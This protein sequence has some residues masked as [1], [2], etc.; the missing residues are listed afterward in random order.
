MFVKKTTKEQIESALSRLRS[1]F[2]EIK[3]IED[4]PVKKYM[5]RWLATFAPD[6]PLYDAKSFCLPRKLYKNY[7]WHAFS[8]QKTDSYIDEMATEAFEG[9][10]AGKCYVLLNDENIICAVPDGSVFTLE[11]IS[12]FKNIIIIDG[13]FKKTYVHTGNDEF[14]PYYKTYDM[15]ESEDLEPD[16]SLIANEDEEEESSDI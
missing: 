4:I 7:L 6:M 13:D 11:K 5:I 3:Y 16:E 8:F 10:F 15:A 14:G 1:A 2:G 9:S 12:E